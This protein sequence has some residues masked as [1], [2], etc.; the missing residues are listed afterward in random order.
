MNSL[1]DD[2][3]FILWI[4][5]VIIFVLVYVDDI[6]ITGNSEAKVQAFIDLLG[7]RF[8]LKDLDPVSYFID[9]ELICDEIRL[10]L[11]QSKYTTELLHKV[12]MFDAKPVS[13]QMA[14]KPSLIKLMGTVL[15]NPTKYHMVIGS[16]QYLIFTRPDTLLFL[17]T[18]FLSTYINL[19][20]SSG[21][22]LSVFYATFVVLGIRGLLYILFLEYVFSSCIF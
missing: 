4:D 20:Q 3:L 17:L 8:L 22:L 18:S 5:K 12:N 11:T 15:S 13:T 6:I 16:L 2:S 7:A 21:L 10:T 14:E 19:H 9:I 1:A